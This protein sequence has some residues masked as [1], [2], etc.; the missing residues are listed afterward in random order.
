MFGLFQT[1]GSSLLP[2]YPL[3]RQTVVIEVK[4]LT[5]QDNLLF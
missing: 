4:D 2:V 1:Y 5:D 3:L